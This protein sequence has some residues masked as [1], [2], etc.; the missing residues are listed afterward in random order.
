MQPNKLLE[1]LKD[2]YLPQEVSSWWPLAY[3]WW[4]VI[5]VII[6]LGIFFL[7]HRRI[8]KKQKQYID[9][10]V[11]DFKES[12]LDTYVSR[13][14]EILQTVSVYLKRVA[15]HKFPKDEIKLLYGQYWVDYLNSKTKKDLFEREVAKNLANTYRPANLSD[16]ELEQVVNAS[17]E[18][19]R[20]VI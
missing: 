4:V 7:V 8:K 17:E 15:I 3:G 10:V 9:S 20:R 19:M 12:V 1:Q 6:F 14:K 18:W 2:I 11:N 5:G 16:A 13:P